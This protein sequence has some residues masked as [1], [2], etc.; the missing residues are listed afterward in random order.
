MRASAQQELE[1]KAVVPDPRATRARLRHAGAAP[2]F[3][4]Q[5]RDRRFDRDGALAA[6][7]EVLRVREYRHADG[8]TEAELTWKGPTRRSAEGYKQREEIELSIGSGGAAPA[9]LLHALGYV[10]V[11]TVERWIETYTLGE[12]SVRLEWYPRMDVLVEVEGTPDA[13]EEAIVASGLPRT[14]FT[15]EPLA[16]FAERFAARG[17]RPVLALADLDGGRPGWED[18]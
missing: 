15:A 17:T 6:R 3:A 4:G 11:H 14:S 12:A 9:D 8:S 18:R 16:V 13:I 1:L 2:G 10:P 7:D 5:L